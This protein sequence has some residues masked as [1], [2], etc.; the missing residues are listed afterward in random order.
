MRGIKKLS[1]FERGGDLENILEGRV[2]VDPRDRKRKNNMRIRFNRDGK[3]VKRSLLGDSRDF[4]Q[5]NLKRNESD[6]KLASPKRKKQNSK[7]K[8][9]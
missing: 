2:S 3:P 4:A 9:S 5:M 1:V 6:P 7:S 8:H